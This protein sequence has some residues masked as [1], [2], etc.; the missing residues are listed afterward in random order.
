MAV[1]VNKEIIYA[2]EWIAYVSHDNDDGAWQFHTNQ[3]EVVFEKNAI[4]VS[5]KN[6]VDLDPTITLLADLL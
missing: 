2:G 5:L 1:V 4:L 6:I 3:P